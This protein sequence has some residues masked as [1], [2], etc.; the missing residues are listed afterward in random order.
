MT[1]SDRKI[2]EILESYDG[3][4]LCA[5]GGAAGRVCSEDGAPLCGV[6]RCPRWDPPVQ[7]SAPRPKLINA[8][9]PKVEKLVDMS[10]RRS[11]RTRCTRAWW[12]WVHRHR[13]HD[14]AG[15]PG[16]EDRVAG[17]AAAHLSAVVAGLGP[18]VAVRLG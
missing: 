16:G 10:K 5:F 11:V 13:A 9:L 18:V 8:F 4:R 1:K 15:G 2:M 17:W 3:P 12:R 14:A 6:T 7:T